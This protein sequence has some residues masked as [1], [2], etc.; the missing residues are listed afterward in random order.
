M[1]VFGTPDRL[2]GF[3]DVAPVPRDS[4]KISDNLRR[5]QRYNRRLQRVFYTSALFSVRRCEESRRF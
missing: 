5:P 1:T 3:G 4:G 2:A